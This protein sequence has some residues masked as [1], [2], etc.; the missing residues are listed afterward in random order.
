MRQSGW[1]YGIL[2][3]SC[4][5]FNLAMKVFFQ[6]IFKRVQRGAK[7]LFCLEIKSFCEVEVTSF[8]CFFDRTSQDEIQM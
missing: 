1:R 4:P 8:N 5:M 2:P 3:F 7:N 6:I